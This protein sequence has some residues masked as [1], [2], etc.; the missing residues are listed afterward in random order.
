M[1]HHFVIIT[2]NEN[3]KEVP[4][5]YLVEFSKL[6]DI[7]VNMIIDETSIQ[8]RHYGYYW[9]YVSVIDDLFVDGKVTENTLA[10]YE[11]LKQN[12]T[13]ESDCWNVNDNDYGP[14]DWKDFERQMQH[15]KKRYLEK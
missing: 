12:T 2:F 3:V 13:V 7:S 4:Y 8:F 5:K 11:W 9:D 1:A 14:C 6:V 10:A 15:I